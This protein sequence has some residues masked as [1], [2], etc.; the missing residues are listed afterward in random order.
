V[1][2]FSAMIGWKKPGDPYS[3]GETEGPIKER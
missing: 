1:T 3:S 2:A